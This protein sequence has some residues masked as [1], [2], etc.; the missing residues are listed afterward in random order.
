MNS[1]VWR[2]EVKEYLLDYILLTF[3][4]LIVEA[5]NTLEIS[6]CQNY[7]QDLTY[8]ANFGR[9]DQQFC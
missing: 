3:I 8:L 1:E 5:L 6:E 4:V 7:K 2:E 9:F